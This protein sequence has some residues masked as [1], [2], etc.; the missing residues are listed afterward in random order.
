MFAKTVGRIYTH[1]FLWGDQDDIRV[2]TMMA[3]FKT[4]GW[5]ERKA[6]QIGDFNAENFKSVFE[7]LIVR[8]IG[9]I[10]GL[11]EHKDIF[12]GMCRDKNRLGHQIPNLTISCLLVTKGRDPP[13]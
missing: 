1:T 9:R 10:N 5:A 3:Y 11:H 6:F 2:T 4:R 13:P 8:A 7:P 12:G